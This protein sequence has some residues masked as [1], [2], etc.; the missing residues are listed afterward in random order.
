MTSKASVWQTPASGQAVTLRTELPQASRVV[1]PTAARRRKIVGRVLDVHEVKLDVLPGGDVADA[2]GIFLGQV[3]QHAHLLG[4]ER[5]ERDLDPLHA[6]GVPERLGAL[7][8]RAGRGAF[9]VCMP[10]WRWPL[11]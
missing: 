3:G 4:I 10:S 11:S 6:G 5:A 8:Q 7:G 1:I 2:V 9:W